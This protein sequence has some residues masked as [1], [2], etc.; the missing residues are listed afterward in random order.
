LHFLP[1]FFHEI[2]RGGDR[3]LTRIRFN[4]KNINNINNLLFKPA[5]S[6]FPAIFS[7]M[8][9][10]PLGQRSRE[11]GRFPGKKSKTAKLSLCINDLFLPA[12]S[13]SCGQKVPHPGPF[14]TSCPFLPGKK[15]GKF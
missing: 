1:G 9:A 4:E 14:C 2:L 12:K 8:A 10:D 6:Y 3:T 15:Q 13:T 11:R 5:L 7:R